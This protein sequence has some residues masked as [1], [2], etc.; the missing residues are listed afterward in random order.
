MPKD[1]YIYTA[2]SGSNHHNG[3]VA[4]AP[5]H[6]FR[7]RAC[8]RSH[9]LFGRTPSRMAGSAAGHCFIDIQ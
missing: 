7:G 6:V 3:F 8:A 4:S 1:A 5:L 9:A 2:K